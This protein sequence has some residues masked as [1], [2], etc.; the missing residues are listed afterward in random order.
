[1]LN[2]TFP[3]I[4]EFSNGNKITFDCPHAEKDKK[5]QFRSV[6]FEPGFMYNIIGLNGLGKT[7]FLNI[8]SLLTGFDGKYT[9]D[10]K[11]IVQVN[12]GIEAKNKDFIRV[13]LFSYV[14]QDP[15]LINMYS[16]EENIQLVNPIFNF[17]KHFDNLLAKIE[18]TIEANVKD[19]LLFKLRYLQ[20]QKNNSPYYLSGGEKQLL[21]FIRAMINPSHT[22][23]A[24]EPW[25]SMDQKLK[26]FV[27]EQL[28]KYLFNEDVF[29]NIRNKNREK[30]KNTVIIITH[31]HHHRS[32]D[33]FGVMDHEWTKITPVTNRK[34]NDQIEP[35]QLI[36]QRFKRV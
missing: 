18:E 14:F 21:S 36:M 8:I 12:G 29:C 23:F 1:M 34:E 35:G 10:E 22:I 20:K 30:S 28:Y 2:I 31:A 32:E 13:N 16:I 26:N 4:K 3:I 19:Y 27:E 5:Q 7:T 15:H 33:K 11:K 24:D 17:D 6:Y 9:V 25:A